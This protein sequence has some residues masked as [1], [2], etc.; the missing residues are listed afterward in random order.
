MPGRAV[1]VVG[2]KIGVLAATHD[3]FLLWC[4]E[5]G[6]SARDAILLED[7]EDV[8][9][10]SLHADYEPT[11]LAAGHGWGDTSALRGAKDILHELLRANHLHLYLGPP[12]EARAVDF[13]CMALQHRMEA[14]IERTPILNRDGLLKLQQE[15]GRPPVAGLIS[16][17]P[18]SAAGPHHIGNVGIEG[19]DRRAVSVREPASVH[20][21]APDATAQYMM[22][23]YRVLLE[24]LVELPGGN[25]FKAQIP[26]SLLRHTSSP[27]GQR[28]QI[29]KMFEQL[30]GMVAGAMVPST[31]P[32][33]PARPYEGRP[34]EYR[35]DLPDWLEE[36]DDGE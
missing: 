20:Q 7:P 15:R 5:V 10:Y 25:P 35:W 34:E 11:V 21:Y 26:T 33:A 19:Y 8:F 32:P 3:R 22:L 6:V 30:A 1:A 27:R 28:R 16:Q 14:D 17:A 9:T 12:P 36:A 31:P 4:D 23:P 29:R 24:A 18:P 13:V 2:V